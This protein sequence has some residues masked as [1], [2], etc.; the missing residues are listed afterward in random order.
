[1]KI[2]NAPDAKTSITSDTLRKLQEVP[3]MWQYRAQVTISSLLQYLQRQEVGS[4][5]DNPYKLLN[6]FLKRV[7]LCSNS[8]PYCAYHAYIQ[9]VS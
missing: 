9:V 8:R 5:E 3:D 4:H 7:R 1:M 6:Q 2:L